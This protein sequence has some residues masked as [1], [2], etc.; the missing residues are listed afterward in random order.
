M[1]LC[2]NFSHRLFI[3]SYIPQLELRSRFTNSKHRESMRTN[4]LKQCNNITRHLCQSKSSILTARVS[5]SGA[6]SSVL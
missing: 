6:V 5:N 3:L 4:R 2:S 1:R